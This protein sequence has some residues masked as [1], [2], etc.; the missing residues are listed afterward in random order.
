VRDRDIEGGDK[1]DS[2]WLWPAELASIDHLSPY[3]FFKFNLMELIMRS[4]AIQIPAE[5]NYMIEDCKE[6]GR[7]VDERKLVEGFH[8]AVMLLT[9]LVA[10]CSGL[11]TQVPNRSPS[12]PSSIASP[13]SSSSSSFSSTSIS[14]PSSFLASISSSPP[15][16]SP[17]Q[18]TRWCNA[19]NGL[20]L[21]ILT[22]LTGG[23]SSRYLGT[24]SNDSL[25][26]QEG[27]ILLLIG[28]SDFKPFYSLLLS[29]IEVIILMLI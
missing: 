4:I 19:V 28:H 3:C 22:I 17:L 20:L 12:F 11:L 15:C 2:T 14:T 13:A 1:D 24:T 9:W 27:L 21:S 23:A 16:S 25:L 10:R 6:E 18:D 26:Q 7:E 8:C 29:I 5:Y